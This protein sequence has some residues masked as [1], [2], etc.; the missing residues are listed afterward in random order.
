MALPKITQENVHLFIPLKIAKVTEMIAETDGEDW[1]DVII[2][3]YNS[4]VYSDL[5]KEETK[6]W[7]EGATYIYES[8]KQEKQNINK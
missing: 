4:K 2:Q 7:H 1:K 8:F 5:E 3:L 6:L